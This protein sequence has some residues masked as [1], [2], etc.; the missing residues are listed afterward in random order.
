MLVESYDVCSKA[1]SET[2]DWHI[3]AWPTVLAPGWVIIVIDWPCFGSQIHG[4]VWL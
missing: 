2:D 4:G 3:Q 1:K